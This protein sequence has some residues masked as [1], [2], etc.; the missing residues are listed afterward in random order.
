MGQAKAQ[1]E[2][3]GFEERDGLWKEEEVGL[4]LTTA[5]ACV[6]WLDVMWDGPARPEWQLRDVAHL[7]LGQLEL[8]LPAA[9]TR[10]RSRGDDARRPC[11]E[12]GR[13][14]APGHMHSDDVC[15]GCAERHLGVTH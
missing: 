7:P 8:G 1:L 12:C 3:A 6:G 2:A 4:V 13:R 11:R 9:L 14:F 5:G 10:A 15:Q